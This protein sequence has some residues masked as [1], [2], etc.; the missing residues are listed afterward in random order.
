M[1]VCSMCIYAS[2]VFSCRDEETAVLAVSVLPFQF[3]RICQ[4]MQI[5]HL[6]MPF[7]TFCFQAVLCSS[8]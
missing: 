7:S 6:R 3:W 2:Q 4:P 5:E 1:Y 8:E